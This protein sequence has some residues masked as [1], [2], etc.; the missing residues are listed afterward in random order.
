MIVVTGA[1]GYIG[2]RAIRRLAGLGLPVTAMA[3][4]SERLREVIPESVPII[5]ADYDDR[6]SLDR[7]FAKARKLLFVSSDGFA[8]DVMRHHAH[9]IDAANRSPITHAVF[10][11]IIDVEEASPFYFAP[12]YRDAERRLKAARFATSV[13]RCGLYSDFILRHWLKDRLISLPLADARIAPISRDDVAAFIA[14]AMLDESAASWDLTGAKDY[15][16]AEIAAA[17]SRSSG[18]A[19]SYQ[20][21]ADQDYLERLQSKVEDPWPVAFTSLCASIREGRFAATSTHFMK[22]LRRPPEDFE[23]FLTRSQL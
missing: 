11:S 16:M 22:M 1:S 23:S 15:S 8:D 19:Y 5:I 12:A 6:K 17:A 18:E 21:C 9:I 14:Q 13:V 7:A 2:S 3:R 4:D 10:T 20:P